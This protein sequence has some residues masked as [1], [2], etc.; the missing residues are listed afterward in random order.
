MKR[1]GIILCLVSISLFSFAQKKVIRDNQQW[2]QYNNQLKLSGKFTLVTDLSIRRI[3]NFRDWNMAA[4]RTTLGYRYAENL[5]GSSSIA[6]GS[7]YKDNKVVKVEFRVHQDAS[8]TQTFGKV[9][10][11]HRLRVEGRY[12]RNVTDGVIGS[13]SS[14]NFRFRYRLYSSIPI[15]KL[16]ESNPDKKLLLNI[17]DEVF[18]NAGNEIVYNTFDNN[19]AIIGT[20]WQLS[21]NLNCALFYVYQYGQRSAQATY[22][23]SDILFLSLTQKMSLHKKQDPK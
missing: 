23:S 4:F 9:S 18:V 11:Q 17:G 16:S 8:T 21:S 7:L 13:A 1:I 20:T 5:Q 3:N 15:A 6:F 12:F 19:R 14:F 2:I 10:L 22:E